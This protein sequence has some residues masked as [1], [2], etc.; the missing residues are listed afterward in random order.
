LGK[1]TKKISVLNSVNSFRIDVQ[2]LASSLVSLFLGQ[3][4]LIDLPPRTRSSPALLA[5]APNQNNSGTLKPSDAYRSLLVGE[6]P[7]S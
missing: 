2:H 1:W 6:S 4:T 5:F 7:S 3:D